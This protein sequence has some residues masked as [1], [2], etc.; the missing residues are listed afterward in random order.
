MQSASSRK[1]EYRQTARDI[2]SVFFVKKHVFVMVLFGVI[3][4]ALALSL[5]TPPVYEANVQLIVKHNNSKPLVFDQQE[6][7]TDYS[8]VVPEQALNTVIFLLTAPDVL[9]E[10]V[11]K[12]KLASEGD[13]EAIL[14]MVSYLK[15]QIK[16]EPLTMSNVV[17][18]TM[19]GRNP[20][21]V[22]D[23]LDTLI[24]AYIKFYIRVNQATEGRLKFFDTQ[25]DY[26]RVQYDRLTKQLSATGKQMEVIDPTVQKDSS[27]LL[28]RDLEGSRSQ[29]DMQYESLRGKI[30][31]FE[32]TLDRFKHDGRLPGLPSDVVSTYPALVEMERSLAQLTINRQRA[33]NDYMPSS[34]QVQ[35]AVAQVGNM[36]SLI[37]HNMEQIILDLKG[38][39]TSNRRSAQELQS[40]IDEVRRKSINL[41]ADL[42]ELDR[43]ALEHKLAKENYALYSAKTEESRINEEKDRARFANV[44]LANRPAAPNS[45]IF[46][47]PGIIMMLAIPLALVLA[48]A[49]SAM[50]YAMEQ[51]VWTPTDLGLHTNLR[52]LAAFDAVGVVE[53][54][55]FS[56]VNSLR[57]FGFRQ[58]L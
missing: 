54:S 58:D 27:L 37:Q 24:E 41:A 18:V 30:E 14:D 5:L 17:R 33:Q 2:I 47:R 43:L 35:D 56:V 57:R 22:A 8:A 39:M 53:T 34:K 7:R 1:K 36:Q 26:F 19:R 52:L 48:L 4:G 12:H 16:A 9:R 29:L 50:A 11:L 49:F 51:R 10:V 45:P 13:E 20:Q 55:S 44:T 38:Q 21:A 6:S 32:T 28:V 23:Q 40:R 3:A 15:G 25:T 42:L 46:P 31:S